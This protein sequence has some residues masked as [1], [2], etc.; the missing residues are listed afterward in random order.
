MRIFLLAALASGLYGQAIHG[1]IFVGQSLNVGLSGSVDTRANSWALIGPRSTTQPFTPPNLMIGA[2]GTNYNASTGGATY[3]SGTGF[4]PLV[5]NGDPLN[6]PSQ[7]APGNPGVE[8]AKSGALN[9]LRAM[10][11][12]YIGLGGVMG[13]SGT[14]YSGLKRVP[15]SPGLP[16]TGNVS[17]QSI[18]EFMA[19]GKEQADL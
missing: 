4:F 16:I 10:A 6:A 18:V 14:A 12:G 2:D 8:T 13:R 7:W 11:P 5:E 15:T 1:V 19:T 9:T 17:Y 3:P